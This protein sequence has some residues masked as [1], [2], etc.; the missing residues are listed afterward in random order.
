MMDCH[1]VLGGQYVCKVKVNLYDQKPVIDRLYYVKRLPSP[2]LL[3][4]TKGP[5]VR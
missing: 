5:L 2:N 1:S 4:A 3:G